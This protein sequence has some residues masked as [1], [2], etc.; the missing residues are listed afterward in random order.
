MKLRK[1]FVSNSS[2][3]SFIC[4]TKMPLEEV[5]KTLRE[6]VEFYNKHLQT[7][8]SSPIDY[9]KAFDTPFYD[10]DGKWDKEMNDWFSDG[11]GHKPKVKGQLIIN[12]SE[13]NSIPYE[14]FDMIENKFNGQRIHLG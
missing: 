1:G 14:L 6:F 13:D 3:S 5:E 8:Y 10:T 4:D 7:E 2:S 11:Y 9:D 12:S